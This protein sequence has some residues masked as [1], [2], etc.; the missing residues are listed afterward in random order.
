MSEGQGSVPPVD[1]TDG[2]RRTLREL[3]K[4]GDGADSTPLPGVAERALLALVFRGVAFEFRW[5][6]MTGGKRHWSF[7]FAA[8]STLAAFCQGVILGGLIQGIK[9]SNTGR[10]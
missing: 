1:L 2:Q 4:I 5:V 7:V 8:G 6:G 10:L 3:I 9:A